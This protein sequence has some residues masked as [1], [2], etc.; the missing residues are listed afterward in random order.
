MHIILYISFHSRKLKHSTGVVA[1][2]D[3]R[4]FVG[5]FQRD[6]FIFSTFKVKIRLGYASVDSDLHSEKEEQTM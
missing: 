2:K 3:R 1:E 5:G 6:L 4:L